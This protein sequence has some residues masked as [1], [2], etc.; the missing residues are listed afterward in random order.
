MAGMAKLNGWNSQ[1][2]WLEWPR[3]SLFFEHSLR[4]IE[5]FVRNDLDRSAK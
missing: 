5:G 2:K 4:M 1:I 3:H